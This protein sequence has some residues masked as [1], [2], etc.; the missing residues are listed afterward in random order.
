MLWEAF[1]KSKLN[2]IVFLWIGFLAIT[3]MAVFSPILILMIRHFYLPQC[4]LTL[5]LDFIDKSVRTPQNQVTAQQVAL[6]DLTQYKSISNEDY[7]IDL[8]L[9]LPRNDVNRYMGN[10]AIRGALG[11][12]DW[13]SSAQSLADKVKTLDSKSIGPDTVERM[14]ILPYKSDFV[15]MFQRVFFTPYYALGLSTEESTLNIN[16]WANAYRP[17]TE[18]PF[19]MI[20][21]PS[22]LWISH[23]EL[24]LEARLHG[25][26]W[27]LRAYPVSSL[28][29]GSIFVFS[30]QLSSAI[31]ILILVYLKFASDT[32]RSMHP[33]SLKRR[34]VSHSSSYHPLAQEAQHLQTSSMEKKYPENP[35]RAFLRMRDPR[36]DDVSEDMSIEAEGTTIVKS[37]D[38]DS[39]SLTDNEIGLLTPQYP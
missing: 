21:V 5:P 3:C 31:V 33:I 14:A 28:A 18:H 27:L 12:H 15:E 22:E 10:F 1:T 9:K 35:P 16:L 7:S 29:V 26:R 20:T 2:A 38:E 34:A 13:T 36:S 19:L 17:R 11:D 37:A 8:N 24:R 4:A 6:V 23:A 30:S 25:L 39:L 32:G